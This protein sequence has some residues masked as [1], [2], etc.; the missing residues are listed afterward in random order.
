MSD[1]Q[2]YI[3]GKASTG[4]SGRWGEVYNPAT[5]EKTRR[6]AFASA[7]EVDRAVQA[8]TAAFPG[9][10]ATPHLTRARILFKFL[11]LLNRDHDALARVISEEHGKV[12][13]DAQGEITRGLEVVSF[14]SGS[15]RPL[16]CLLSYVVRR[17]IDSWS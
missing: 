11:E 3:H 14:A 5:G 1:V 17:A 13:S 16:K 6:V 9:W 8:A 2:H 12:F 4:A 7:G 10:A 15:P